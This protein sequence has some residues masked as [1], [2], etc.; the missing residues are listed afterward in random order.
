MARVSGAS[1][2]CSSHD[3][4]NLT[5]VSFLG[6]YF[7]C[8]LSCAINGFGDLGRFS[9]R[10]FRSLAATKAHYRRQGNG[11][12]S[13]WFE[14]KQMLHMVNVRFYRKFFNR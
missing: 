10:R 12:G 13:K 3:R 9:G 4:V 14:G 8:Y 7:R 5:G 6:I 2:P 1:T 11:A